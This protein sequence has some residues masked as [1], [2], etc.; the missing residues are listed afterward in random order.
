M[1]WTI[2]AC[3]TTPWPGRI[4]GPEPDFDRLDAGHPAYSE[5]KEKFGESAL[6]G[7]LTYAKTREAVGL[8]YSGDYLPQSVRELYAQADWNALPDHP[9]TATLKRFFELCVEYELAVV[10]G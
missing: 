4:G 9:P 6:H 1:S 5:F 2:S 10:M 3:T 8:P 7:T